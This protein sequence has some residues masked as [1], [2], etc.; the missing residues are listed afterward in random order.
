MVFLCVLR[1]SVVFFSP[2]TK[3][4][5]CELIDWQQFNSLSRQLSQI[6]RD[7]RVNVD[8][9]VAIGRGG[10]MPARLLSDLLGVFNLASFKIEHYRGAHKESRALVKYGLN[11]PV[12]GKNILLVDDVS[13]SG[14]TF[15]VALEHIQ[16]LGVPE[17]IHTAVLHH[18]VV[19]SYV[20]D[21]YAAKVE[22]WRWIIYPWAVTEDL[23]SF[24]AAMDS[25]SASNENI[26]TYLKQSHGI[27]VTE[28]HIQDALR[29]LG[30]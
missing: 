12:D 30:R 29:L 17:Q 20:P 6:I 23:A 21:F 25:K 7:A 9:I 10:Y 8:M 22:Q 19:S 27:S 1:A 18:K 15:N 16:S 28:D 5:P 11:A 2:M 26:A 14:D 24:I 13:D 3:A 4:I